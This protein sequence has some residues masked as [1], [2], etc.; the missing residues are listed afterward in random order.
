MN[1]CSKFVTNLYD[2]NTQFNHNDRCGR[3]GCR[4]KEHDEY[5]EFWKTEDLK[6]LYKKALCTDLDEHE[7]KRLMELL[8]KFYS[9][10]V[11]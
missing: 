10:H 9:E 7:L 4:L 3:C 11:K 5:F 2:K 8:M 1:P 6:L